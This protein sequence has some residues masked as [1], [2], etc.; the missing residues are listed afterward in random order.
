MDPNQQPQ[1]EPNNLTEPERQFGAPTELPTSPEV[2]QVSST[3]EP[4][5]PTES[6]QSSVTP[7]P[8]PFGQPAPETVSATPE[9]TPVATQ[10]PVA[11][12]D[13]PGKTLGIVSIVMSII[14]LS[15]VGIILAVIS[16]KK[17][18]E[19]NASTTLGTI[20]L[21]LGIVFTVLAVL[22]FVLFAGLLVANGMTTSP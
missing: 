9:V 16:R 18:K 8:Q 19:A 22:W 6:A 11:S 7:E 3:P 13:N 2:T 4:S 10:Q 14:G 12:Q 15:I 20:G 17:S 5:T 21:V 1:E